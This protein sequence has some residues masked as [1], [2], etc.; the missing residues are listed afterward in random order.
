MFISRLIGLISE[1]GISKNKMLKDL[2]LGAGT[3]A[4]WQARN[5]IPN[6]EI[7][8]RLADYFNVTTDYLLG[9]T[10]IKKEPSPERREKADYLMQLLI[11]NDVIKEDYTSDDLARVADFVKANAPFIKQI[12]NKDR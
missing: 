11:E 8:S 7:L 4:T 1:K 3:L 12:L 10:D 5:S 9:N 6:G 2:G